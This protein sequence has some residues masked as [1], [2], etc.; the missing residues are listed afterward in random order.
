MIRS[1]PVFYSMDTPSWVN[2]IH[3]SGSSRYV[4]PIVLQLGDEVRIRIRTSLDAP[5]QRIILRTCPD[6]EQLYTPMQPCLMASSLK[7][8]SPTNGRLLQMDFSY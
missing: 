4:Q 2:L 5:N 3:H 7:S 8:C 1:Q 6:G